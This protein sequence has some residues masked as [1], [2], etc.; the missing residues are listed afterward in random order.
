MNHRE[1]RL[2]S[3][4]SHHSAWSSGQLATHGHNLDYMSNGYPYDAPHHYYPSPGQE[5]SNL[6]DS[7]WISPIL[8]ITLLIARW[9]WLALLALI[10]AA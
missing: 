3:F 9:Q 10:S 6:S 4:D 7:K 5:I 8:F 2:Y 1:P